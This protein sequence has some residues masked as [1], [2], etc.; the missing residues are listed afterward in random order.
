MLSRDQHFEHFDVVIVGAGLSGIGAA[1][2]LKEQCPDKSFVILESLPSFG[3][4]WWTHRYP[5]TRSDSDLYTYGYRFK[6]WTGAPIAARDEILSYLGAVIDDD[7]LGQHIRYGHTVTQASWSSE[8]KRWTLRITRAEGGMVIVGASFLWMCQGYYRHG[9]GYTPQWS[10]LE[11]FS[12]RL[13]HPQS[14]PQDLNYR[15]KNVV[16]I[17]S[18]ATAATLIPAIAG[19]CRHVTMLQRSPTFF[20]IGT[21]VNELADTLRELDI[22]DAWVHEIV[23][24]K[25]LLDFGII[26]QLALEYPELAREE[27]LKPVREIL[28]EDYDIDTHFNPRYKPWQQ[29]IAM[30]PDGD[31]FRCIKDGEVTVVTDEIEAFNET[32]ITLA[33]GRILEADVIITATGFTMS[34][35]GDIEI[36]IDGAPLDVA[37]TITY[38]GL[39]LTGLPNLVQ[40]FGYFR[41]SWTLRVDLI[42]DFVCRLLRHMQDL[43][44]SVVTPTLRPQ[45]EGMTLVSWVNPEDFNPGYLM[46]TEAQLPQ[47]GDRE[48]W[49]NDMVYEVE[50][51]AL[52]AADLDDGALIFT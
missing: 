44:V 43:G 6:P 46:R 14:W 28:G 7:S 38:R 16:V 48:P 52:P 15:D 45:D 5:G 9:E 51:V 26:T 40:V 36:T 22:P 18:G 10:G 3:G 41:A 11:K 13:V 34:V 49:R 4:T 42:G 30:V 32:G 37:K 8:E 23:R 31:L 25:I 17:G 21:N 2:H 27:L 24:Q 33:S 19:Q 12:G 35:L 29:R 39:M 50:K 20:F 1:H 47:Q